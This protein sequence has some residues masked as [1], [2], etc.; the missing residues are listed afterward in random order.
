MSNL[1]RAEIL[2]IEAEPTSGGSE[3]QTEVPKEAGP[4]FGGSEDP[5]GEE[6]IYVTFLFGGREIENKLV[7]FR[8]RDPSSKLN[9]MW[10]V[11]LPTA[12]Q[13]GPGSYDNKVVVFRQTG[14]TTFSLNALDENRD[15]EAIANLKDETNV[16]T[17]QDDGDREYGYRM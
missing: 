10:R 9:S 2:W 12:N 7:N 11:N 4:F 13:G 15:Q 3:N 14:G 16:K 8:P 17:T 6:R 5:S 1:R